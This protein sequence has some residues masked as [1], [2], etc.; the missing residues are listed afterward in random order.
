MPY[1]IDMTDEAPVSRRDRNK[2]RTRARILDAGRSLFTEK[3]VAGTTIED[4]AD[5]ADVARATFF[6]YFPSKT[7]VVEEI[8]NA[9]DIGFFRLLS[10]AMEGDISTQALLASFFTGSAKVIE[11][12][13]EFFRVIIAESEKSLAGLGTDNDRYLV[14]IAQFKKMIDR[15]VARGEVRTDYP[16]DLLAEIL[17]GAYAT[18]LRS[19]RGTPGYKLAER[20]NLTAA[21]M[22]DFLSA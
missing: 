4:L 13:P 14:M 17:V 15:G 9:H 11:A 21:V 16:S 20:L 5:M 8:L 22:A 12:S 1:G 6:N 18:V 10:Q 19:W 3:G 7:A 2:L